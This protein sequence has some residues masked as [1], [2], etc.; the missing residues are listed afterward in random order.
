MTRRDAGQVQGEPDPRRAKGQKA[1]VNLGGEKKDNRGG[2]G[3]EKNGASTNGTK[4]KGTT[5]TWK[6]KGGA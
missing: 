6:G 1:C 2:D 3:K 5:K 4:R